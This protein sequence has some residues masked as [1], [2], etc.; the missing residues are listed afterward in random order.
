MN[1][2][3]IILL[4]LSA[5]AVS[6]VIDNVPCTGRD[7]RNI[8]SEVNEIRVVPC[9]EAE[10]SEPCQLRRG[11]TARIEV[12]FTPTR[13]FRRIK[14]AMLWVSKV[15]LPF[16]GMS[17]NACRSM[18]CPANSGTQQSFNTT[19]N[20]GRNLPVGTYPI[21]FKLYEGR[22]ILVCQTLTIKLMDPED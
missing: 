17:A 1:R 13:S 10:D 14:A 22:N 8:M 4:G 7:G 3:I 9:A 6:E 11:S 16:R 15:E 21:K 2:L 12:D 20:L 18:T 5:L 19:L